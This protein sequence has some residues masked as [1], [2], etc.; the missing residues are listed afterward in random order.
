MSA[1]MNRAAH[2]VNTAVVTPRNQVGNVVVARAPVASCSKS[3]SVSVGRASFSRNAISKISSQKNVSKGP[4]SCT[5][6]TMCVRA[7]AT[8]AELET[9]GDNLEL[10]SSELPV[11]VVDETSLTS[12]EV[13]DSLDTESVAVS[14]PSTAVETQVEEAPKIFCGNLS[15]SMPV[16]QLQA[17]F[18]EFGTVVQANI[19][20]DPSTG[21]S[22]G[23][24]FVTMG[25]KEEARAALEGLNGQ[26]VDGRVIRLDPANSGPREPRESRPRTYNNR[27]QRTY[28]NPYRVYVGNLP[29]RID[30]YSLED[31]FSEYGTVKDAKVMTDRESGRSRG[32]GFVTMSSDEEVSVACSSL[33]GA[34]WEGRTLR[35][36]KAER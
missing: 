29:W 12:E 34:D 3:L 18:E 15:W 9:T 10:V 16:E 13:A 20:T 17:A 33:D 8:E 7:A 31:A 5:A 36:N 2:K 11:D 26:D 6:L 19:V 30:D 35:V 23:F 24:G 21:R 22:K 32:F 28:D 4:P 25:S 14:E 1:V 27:Q